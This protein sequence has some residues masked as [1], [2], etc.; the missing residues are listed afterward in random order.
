M[1]S[2]ASDFWPLFW[3]I[4]SGGAALTVLACLLVA[5]FSPAWF[6]HDRHEPARPL[7]L[8]TASGHGDKAG[9]LPTAA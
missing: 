1:L 8:R 4:V 6:R 3:V 2:F 5:V 9:G 7:P